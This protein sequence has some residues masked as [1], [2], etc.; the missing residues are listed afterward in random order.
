MDTAISIQNLSKRFGGAVAVNDVTLSASTGKPCQGWLLTAL[1]RSVQSARDRAAEGGQE[2]L[3]A[4]GC[5]QRVQLGQVGAEPGAARRRGTGEERLGD[6]AQGAELLLRRGLMRP[7]WT[8][9]GR[10][11]SISGK[12]L[13][14]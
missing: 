5:A 12:G 9:A 7:R 8:R 14:Q 10:R 6:R 3:V 2:L 1:P 11:G 13:S 4:V